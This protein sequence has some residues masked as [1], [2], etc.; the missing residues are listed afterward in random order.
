MEEYDSFPVSEIHGQY[1]GDSVRI[2][3]P[4]MAYAALTNNGFDFFLFGV[5][6]C[7]HFIVLLTAIG[8]QKYE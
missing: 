6:N 8:L 4:D 2:R 7:F 5:Y 3:H 1:V